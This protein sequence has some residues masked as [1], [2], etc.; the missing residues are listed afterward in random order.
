MPIS[1]NNKIQL[2]RCESLNPDHG[3]HLI[4]E[5][6]HRLLTRFRDRDSKRR[7]RSY[8]EKNRFIRKLF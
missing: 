4:K 5:K 1:I 3:R 8:R 7:R 6:Q 2:R